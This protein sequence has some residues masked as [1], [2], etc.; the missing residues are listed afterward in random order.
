M[1]R[2]ELV[3]I[4]P[5][6]CMSMGVQKS[7]TSEDGKRVISHMPI[8]YFPYQLSQKTFQKIC[9]LHEVWQKLIV[10]VASDH[11]LMEKIAE[12]MCKNDE[13]M[14]RL[15][16]LYTQTKKENSET[17][18]IA[19]TRV[20]YM[21]DEDPRLVE[22]NLMSVG[23]NGNSDKVQELGEI[24][25][26]AQKENTFYPTSK[27][28]TNICNQL[29]TAMEKNHSSDGIVVLVLHQPEFNF[30]D[31]NFFKLEMLKRGKIV[32]SLT[33]EQLL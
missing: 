20:D 29:V 9:I 25:D 23:L 2:E 24:V 26:T 27:N 19:C 18:R 32:V 8:S 15:W 33:V 11:K 4:I 6:L 13:F 3:T 14:K 10:A 21:G 28:Q 30:G 31:Q 1:R 16:D 5:E 22:F 7:I 17:V 12:N